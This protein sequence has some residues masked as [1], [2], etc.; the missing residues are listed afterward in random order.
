[1]DFIFQILK[2]IRYSSVNEKSYLI[3]FPG[4]LRDFSWDN[5][6]SIPDWN[7]LIVL[8]GGCGRQY[9]GLGRLESNT[10]NIPQD[11]AINLYCNNELV[12]KKTSSKLILQTLRAD[13]LLLIPVLSF[14]SGICYSAAIILQLSLTKASGFSIS[15]TEQY[16]DRV[17][18][19]LP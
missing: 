19:I 3:C 1:M 11:L 16:R 10:V 17:K 7:L 2:K 9:I 6:F 18:E 4:T 5:G 12:V 8:S 14:S 15:E 13:E